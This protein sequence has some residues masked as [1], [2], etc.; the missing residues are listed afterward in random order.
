MF[1]GTAADI[2]CETDMERKLRSYRYSQ[3]LEIQ[4]EL[5]IST[6]DDIQ[7]WL[8]LHQLLKSH[9]DR[10]AALERLGK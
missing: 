7:A 2:S 3:Q 10:I 9:E 8:R 5:G 4:R 1:G 6:D